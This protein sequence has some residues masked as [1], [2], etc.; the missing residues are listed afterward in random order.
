MARARR[1]AGEG[2][3]S[4]PTSFIAG[5]GHISSHR[6]RASAPASF[7]KQ[8]GVEAPSWP[9]K[10]AGSRTLH[11]P[12]TGK[13]LVLRNRGALYSRPRHNQPGPTCITENQEIDTAGNHVD[14][15]DAMP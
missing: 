2:A 9:P 10:G 6:G 7:A 15:K 1:S 5:P 13:E 11:Q 8:F 14:G 4:G 12:A 3:A